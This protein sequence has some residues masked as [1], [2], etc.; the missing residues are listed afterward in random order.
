MPAGRHHVLAVKKMAGSSGPWNLPWET[1][2][3]AVRELTLVHGDLKWNRPSENTLPEDMTLDCCK[4]G[5]TRGVRSKI[6][7]A[8]E[9]K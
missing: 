7:F 9:R 4:N 6:E 1:L 8:V 3:R 2:G 5:S